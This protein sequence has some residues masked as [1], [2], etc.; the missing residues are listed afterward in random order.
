MAVT[1]TILTAIALAAPGQRTA[2]GQLAELERQFQSP[3]RDARCKVIWHWVEG[4]VSREGITAD[5]EA[6][7]QANLA[8]AYLLTIKAPADPPLLEPPAEQFSDR[9]WQLVKHAFKDADR[10]GLE[11]GLHVCDGFATAG[12]PWITP[13]LSM[14]R[15]VWSETNVIGGERLSMQLAR[16]VADGYYK[17]VAVLAYP[18]P[19]AEVSEDGGGVSS[20]PNLPTVTTSFG[21][22][23]GVFDATFLTELD[24]VDERLRSAEPCWIQYEFARP[25]LCRSIRIV[26]DGNNFQANRL[27]VEASDDGQQFREVARLQPPRH[28]WQDRDAEVTHAI[29]ATSARFFRFRWDPAGS[30]PGSEDLDSAKWSPVLKIRGIHLSSVARVHQF[31]AKSGLVW[32]VSPA[33]TDEQVSPEICVPLDQV[34]DLSPQMDAA[35]RLTWE[36]P[37]G[38][39]VV[40][41]FG[42]ASTGHE[43]STGGGARGLECDKLNGAAARLQF[44]NWFGGIRGFVGED[45]AGRVLTELFMDSWECGSQN[46]TAKFPQEFAR[47]Q[48]YELTRYLPAMAGVPISSAAESE[49]VLRDVRETIAELLV[50]EFFGTMAS[51]AAEHDCRVVAENVAPAMLSD[52]MAHFAKVDVPMGEFWLNSPTHDKP[53]DMLD[54]ISA[55]HIYGKRIVQAEALTQLRIQWN[56]HPGM[57]KALGDRHFCLGVNRMVPH[58]FAENPWLDRRPGMTLGGVGLFFQRGQTWWKPGKAWLDYL[59]RCQAVLQAGEPVVDVAVFTGEELPRR[60]ILPDRLAGVL[61]DVIGDEAVS[62]ERKRLANSGQPLREMPP[63]VR[64]SANMVDPQRWLDPLRGLKYDS[65]NRDALLRL[66]AVE[67]GRIVLPGGASY[68]ALVIPGDRPMNPSGDDLSA[69]V[70]ERI[71][72]VR[73]AQV[74]VLSRRDAPLGREGDDG[75]AI[76]TLP[77]PDFLVIQPDGQPADGVAWCHRRLDDGDIYFV[78]NQLEERR[79]LRVSLRA[80]GRA[81][82]LWDAVAGEISVAEFSVEE[83][84]CEVELELPS[85]GAIF[86]V[87][88]GKP[89]EERAVL[90]RRRLTVTDADKRVTLALDQ[91]WT[92]SFESESAMKKSLEVDS[93]FDWRAHRDSEIRHFSGTATYETRFDWKEALDRHWL[94]LGQV[95]NLAE[96]TL[97]GKP[98]G[99]TWTDPHRVAI[100]SALQ[101]GLN[102]LQIRVTNTWANRMIFEAG[103]PEEKRTLWT[104]G[105]WPAADREL[106]PSGLLGPV[107]ILGEL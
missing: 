99:T 58:V 49:R 84:R 10:L 104:N 74:C 106:E 25:F 60:A 80:S 30:E 76:S 24:N 82:E 101:S 102:V 4:C 36:A 92:V 44:A 13:E 1:L 97:N 105:R 40:M 56:E 98:C 38:H 33:T 67:D 11:L 68:A 45:V 65:L 64:H 2:H 32:R 51:L 83:D 85:C 103:L 29:P 26:R 81:A 19:A 93:L 86:V 28:G 87:V 91:A 72:K 16:P 17:D 23:D 9:W 54:A 20:E 100:G 77:R 3:P 63:G 43:N 34:V 14:Q 94:D 55:A 5:L 70:E 57:L 88:R 79:K 6:M 59:A 73:A 7:Q 47:M 95:A 31:E 37:R 53:N 18:N 46:W 50:E 22:V 48:G 78:S 62:R 52:G 35:G 75:T 8:G 107:V 42:H 90:T 96:V 71:A 39:W 69:E 27:T 61:P 66:A 21:G 41:R 12:G 89:A 15:L